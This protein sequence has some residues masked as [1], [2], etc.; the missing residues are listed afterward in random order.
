MLIAVA[1]THV[2]AI[3]GE[4]ASSG[5]DRLVDARGQLVD[6]GARLVVAKGE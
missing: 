1:V 3:V 5:D 4:P 2:A 6:S